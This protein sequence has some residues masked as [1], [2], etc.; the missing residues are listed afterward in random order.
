[1][2]KIYCGEILLS[3]QI[4]PE[5]DIKEG[6]SAFFTFFSHSAGFSPIDTAYSLYNDKCS[7]NL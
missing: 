3:M 6:Q 7:F 1:M 2:I 5:K 4:K